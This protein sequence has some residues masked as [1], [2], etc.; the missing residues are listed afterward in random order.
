M[1]LRTALF[2]LLLS[3]LAGP[4]SAREIT[5]LDGVVVGVVDGDTADVRLDSGM[6]RV[7]LHAIDTPERGQAYGQAARSALAR[8]V[9]G[10]A[11]QLEPVEQDQ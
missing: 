5:I 4:A 3:F 6:V 11:I 9:F 10:K 7:R 1:T 8:L 2:A